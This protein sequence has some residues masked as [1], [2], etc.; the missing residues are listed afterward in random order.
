[1]STLVPL[2]RIVERLKIFGIFWPYWAWILCS[3]FLNLLTNTSTRHVEFISCASLWRDDQWYY[4]L[5]TPNHSNMHSKGF[6]YLFYR[7]SIYW[8]KIIGSSKIGNHRV[9]FLLKARSS[10]ICI[11]SQQQMYHYWKLSRISCKDHRV[12]GP[13]EHKVAYLVSFF[14]IIAFRYGRIAPRHL[15]YAYL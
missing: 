7:L 10:L 11:P 5:F 8:L 15:S 13:S 4:L 3:G 12:R 14:G 6:D 2:R 1:M 9:Y